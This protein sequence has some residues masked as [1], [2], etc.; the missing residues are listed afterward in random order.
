MAWGALVFAAY[1]GLTAWFTWPLA[2]HLNDAVTSAIDPVDNVWRIAW[3]QHQLLHDPRHLLAG[4]VFYPY[5]STYL[6]DGLI[7][8]AA[9][10]TLPLAALALPPLAI[11]NCAVLLAFTL[12]GVGMYACARHFGAKRIVAFTAG[13]IYAFA[14]MHLDRVGHVGIASVA[15]FPLI[16]LFT[17]Q[18]LTRPRGRDTVALAACLVLQSFSSQYYALYLLV[19]M[20][21]FLAVM[22]VRRPETRRFRAL[23]HL[24]AAGIVAI[25]L[26]LPVALPF[27]GIQTRY[28]VGRSY[29]QITYYAANLTS[30]VTADGMNRLW[31]TWTAPLR[32]S[33]TYTFERLMFPGLLALVLAACGLW[34]G[35]QRPWE[36][37]LALLI[38]A[39]AVLALG[40]E[41][42]IAPGSK[43]V[44][45]GHLPYDVLY[46]HLPG[47]DSM[48]VPARFGALFLLGIAGLTASGL[49][50]L[51]GKLAPMRFPRPQLARL[52]PIAGS[53]VVLLGLGAE[54]ANHPLPLVPLNSTGSVPPAYRWLAANPGGAVIELPLVIPDHTHEQEIAV[55]EQYFSLFHAHPLVNG[56]ANVIP[57]GYQALVTEM[58]AFPSAR[59]V[60]LLQG[61]GVTNVVVHFDQMTGDAQRAT[62][63]A[64]LAAAGPDLAL[65]AAFGET[66]IY[67][68]APT[69]RFAALQATIPTG[70]SVLL[71]RN[72]PRQ[73]GA[74]MAMLGYVLRD[75]PL[76]ANLRV[77]FGQDYGV[78]R[79]SARYDYAALFAD[80]DPATAGFAG[81]PIIWQDATVRIY[82]HPV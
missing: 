55:R 13:G 47:W 64:K 4:N 67:R 48:R 11:Y 9:I 42:R 38:A 43:T 32:A 59:T 22:L 37:F 65:A 70:A 75:H 71:S 62:L 79:P 35:R 24:V 49:T 41:V 66:V 58:P 50:W 28:D 17:D 7:L 10:V 69:D 74:Y 68:V 12:C 44:L 18:I 16:L 33:G 21:L 26:V 61:L 76:Y 45:L 57:K 25:A 78:M 72:D 15:W 14:P 23:L 2:A 73:T 52:L 54:Y 51:G 1:L 46:W 3:G 8:G 80:E 34:A 60:A 19:L 36:Q 81:A 53:A 5:A 40:P 56:N 20:P 77:N 29:G 27:R 31:G 63:Q 39:S 6:F 30:F 82:R